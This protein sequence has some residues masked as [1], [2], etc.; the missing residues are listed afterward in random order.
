MRQC[1]VVVYVAALQAANLRWRGLATQSVR[2]GLHKSRNGELR[3]RGLVALTSTSGE[4]YL[5]FGYALGMAAFVG[6]R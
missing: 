2:P 4:Q 3:K 1:P 6:D 5:D